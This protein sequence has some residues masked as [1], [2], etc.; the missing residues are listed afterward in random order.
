MT[1]AASFSP[2]QAPPADP[3]RTVFFG[4]PLKARVTARNWSNTVR[5][6]NRTLASIYN[7]TN[8]N[9]RVLVGC[10]EVPDLMF[11]T[12]HRLKFLRIQAKPPKLH[13]VRW[14]LF[15]DR[16]QKLRAIGKRFNREGG[17]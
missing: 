9:F 3:T 4:I 12:D 16:A 11:P 2:T 1:E 15:S 10:H 7:Q 8:P 13:E 6:F 17:R 5:D 14:G